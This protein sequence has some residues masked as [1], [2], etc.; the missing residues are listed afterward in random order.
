MNRRTHALI[1]SA[2][3][4]LARGDFEA[5][6]DALKPVVACANGCREAHLEAVG[7][8]PA[9]VLGHQAPDLARA[10][11]VLAQCLEARRR[12]VVGVGHHHA[13]LATG[14]SA[15]Q[16]AASR[17][18]LVRLPWHPAGPRSDPPCL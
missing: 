8:R 1:S 12:A 6:V 11:Q 5:V 4:L 16:P 7:C 17:R 15:F 9:L 13:A 14:K 2:H 10:Q 3:A 18:L